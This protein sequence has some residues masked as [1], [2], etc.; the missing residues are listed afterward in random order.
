MPDPY[1]FSNFS[2]DMPKTALIT[3]ASS[4]IGL[5]FAH[6]F[7]EQGFDIILVARREEQLKALGKTLRTEYGVLTHVIPTDLADPASPQI[8]YDTIKEKKL[9]VDVLVNNAGFAVFS[10]FLE[11]DWQQH[12]NLMQV[13]NTSLV[14]LCYLFAADMKQKQY[15][16]IVNVASI[17]AFLPQATGSL[18][19][20]AKAFVVGFSQAINLELKPHGVHCTALCPGLTRSEFFDKLGPRTL[21]R[22]LP[23]FLWMDARKVATEGYQAVMEGKPVHING[24]LNTGLSQLMM[25]MPLQ[26][27]YFLAKKQSWL[28]DLPKIGS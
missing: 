25:S 28:G 19:C 23:K 22:H 14:E 9:S 4:G 18:Y 12:A 21:A 15:G 20:A 16:R 1:D 27:K 24:R 6:V 26:A 11:T 17:A 7:A 5:E 13:L 3:G 8:L 2:D 10:G